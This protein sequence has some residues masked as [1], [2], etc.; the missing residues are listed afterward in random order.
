MLT[1]THPAAEHLKQLLQEVDAPQDAAARFV[2]SSDGLSLQLDHPRD[3]D[4]SYNHDGRTVLLIDEQIAD[5]L[6]DRTL[7][8]E[9]TDE[10]PALT[11]Q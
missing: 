2:A 7:D 1:M 6:S 8:L 5:L 10:G 9:E 11:L 3:G 4:E